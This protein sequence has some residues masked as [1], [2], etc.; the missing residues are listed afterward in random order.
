[1]PLIISPNPGMAIL[2]RVNGATGEVE[3][4]GLA[5]RD[6]RGREDVRGVRPEAADLA[7]QWIESH[8]AICRRA[9]QVA[10]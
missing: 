3:F 8:Q 2:C 10:A 4:L 6:E 9:A 5:E 1:M 7:E